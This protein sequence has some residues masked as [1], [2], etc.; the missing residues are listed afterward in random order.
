MAKVA[1]S[2]NQ[3]EALLFNN[4]QLVISLALFNGWVF[5]LSWSGV[6]S[7]PFEV[8]LIGFAM[9]GL[10]LTSLF[11]CSLVLATFFIFSRLCLNVSTGALN[12]SS[13]FMSLGIVLVVFA[14]S[15]FGQPTILYLAG[16]VCTGLG[17]GLFS[18]YWG[19]LITRY[20]ASVVL[21]FMSIALLLGALFCLLTSVLADP[22][23]WLVMLLVPVLELMLFK[24]AMQSDIEP[25]KEEEIVSRA[26]NRESS[27]SHGSASKIVLFLVLVVVLGISGGL[28][29]G[30]MGTSIQSD[31]NTSVFCGA[32]VCAAVML[33]FSRVPERGEP[34]ALFYRAIGFIAA[35]FVVLTIVTQHT[36]FALAIHTAGFVYFYG[37]LWVFCVIYAQA[38]STPM[39]IF[40]GGL[41]ANQC[42]QLIGAACGNGMQFLFEPHSLISSASNLMIY[43]LLFVVI[44]LLARLSSSASTQRT[45]VISAS[46]IDDACTLASEKFALTKREAEILRFLIYGYDRTYIA[47]KLT[48]SPETVKTHT[49]HIYEKCDAHSRVELFNVIVSTLQPQE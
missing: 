25:Q 33:A 13:L 29:R 44:I 49:R 34:F 42:G 3:L 2:V 22:V 23:A 45:P 19:A 21:C 4:W 35:G 9:N 26:I 27:S 40:V 10:W 14:I 8:S 28:L 30:L 32:T 6:F 17:T 15:G 48:V 11:V 5:A 43:L 7:A 24:Q 31:E 20:D 47:T 16:G 18:A 37:L 39:H 36:S 12:A 38:D 46:T 41:L 1:I